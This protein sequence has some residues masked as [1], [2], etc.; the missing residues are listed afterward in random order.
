MRL[1]ESVSVR[2]ESISSNFYSFS[3]LIFLYFQ[4]FTF[5]PP[6]WSVVIYFLQFNFIPP[7]WSVALYF[8]HFKFLKNRPRGRS[9]FFLFFIYFQY[10]SFTPLDPLGS[11]AVVIFFSFLYLLLVLYFYLHH[12]ILLD[13]R[14]S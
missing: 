1:T 8:L 3:L 4:Q 14:R 11:E 12:S 13:P 9:Y 2:V 5:I 6:S 10:F 7:S